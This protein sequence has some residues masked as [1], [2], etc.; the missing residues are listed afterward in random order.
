MA[1]SRI[2][3]KPTTAGLSSRPTTN[4]GWVQLPVLPTASLTDAHLLGAAGKPVRSLATDD[5]SLAVMSPAGGVCRIAQARASVTAQ[6][7]SATVGT[8]PGTVGLLS[9]SPPSAVARL[10]LSSSAAPA[11]LRMRV[12]MNIKGPSDPLQLYAVLYDLTA[13]AGGGVSASGALVNA[14]TP[15]LAAACGDATSAEARVVEWVDWYALSSGTW[16][17]QDE[18]AVQVFANASGNASVALTGTVTFDYAAAGRGA[19]V[20]ALGAWRARPAVPER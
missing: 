9:G 19:D 3:W 11:Y 4:G 1:A 2:A 13:N 20:R 15:M 6:A 8:T 17:D 10:V 12:V 14:V 16:A 7:V 5:L 18:L